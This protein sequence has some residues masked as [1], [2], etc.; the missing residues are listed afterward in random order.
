[1]SD[2]HHSGAAAEDLAGDRRIVGRPVIEWSDLHIFGALAT[3]S[4][5]KWCQAGRP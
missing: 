5:P 1:M 2:V 3:I 4:S